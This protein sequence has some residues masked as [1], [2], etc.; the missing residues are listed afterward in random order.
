MT[1]VPSPE[2]ESALIEA[3]FVREKQERVI[4]KLRGP[5]RKRDA[6]LREHL[7]H[8]S[9]WNPAFV[10]P[11]PPAAQTVEAV[12]RELLRRGAAMEAAVYILSADRN[13]DTRVCSLRDALRDVVGT[14]T[15]SVISCVRG[16]L[17]YYE[18][19]EPGNRFILA[20]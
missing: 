1:R 9:R 6:E 18:G 10:V 13:L 19:E 11:I 12:G 15:G 4:R 5:L 16:K 8:E 14:S 7:P 2:D 17:A 3:F 20:R